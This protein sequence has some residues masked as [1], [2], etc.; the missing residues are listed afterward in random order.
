MPPDIASL[1]TDMLADLSGGDRR[2][3]IAAVRRGLPVV[4]VVRLLD[5]GRMT[6]N[7]IE[8]TVLP[9]DAL[10]ERARSGRLSPEESDRLAR[11]VRAIA[12]A[13]ETFGSIERAAAWLRRPSDVLDGE[14]PIALLDTSEGTRDVETLLGR[15]AHGLGA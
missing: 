4:G 10:P 15:I 2:S 12:A 1:P 5:A 3:R 14:A 13:E 8:R 6:L 11:V 7:E 9:R